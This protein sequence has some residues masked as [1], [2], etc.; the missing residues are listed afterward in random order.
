[1]QSIITQSTRCAP[2]QDH[3]RC[4]PTPDPGSGIG[5]PPASTTVAAADFPEDRFLVTAYR[6]EKLKEAVMNE[7]EIRTLDPSDVDFHWDRVYGW[8]TIKLRHGEPKKYFGSIP[9]VGPA[10]GVPFLEE[11]MFQPGILSGPEHLQRNPSLTSFCDSAAVASRLRALRRGFNES[12][13][14]PW[15]FVSQARP[16]RIAWNADRSWRIIERLARPSEGKG[17]QS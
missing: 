12:G 13:R 7:E 5:K 10:V 1:M 15:Y 14:S 16:Y 6:E 2:S 4:E 11:L 8:I 9:G 3:D 17:Q